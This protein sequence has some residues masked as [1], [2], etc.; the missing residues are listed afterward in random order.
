MGLAYVLILSAQ[1]CTQ[2]L[3]TTKLVYSKPKHAS[4]ACI[5]FF[6]EHKYGQHNNMIISA[7]NNIQSKTKTG[8]QLRLPQTDEVL[9]SF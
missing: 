5:Q 3:I 9:F 1:H 6:P 8:K 7:S 4:S 2:I